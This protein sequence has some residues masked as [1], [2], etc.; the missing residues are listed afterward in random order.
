MNCTRMVATTAVAPLLWGTTYLT[1]T[2]LLP[3]D[4]PLLASAVRALPAGLVLIG[5]TRTLPRGAWWWKSAVLGILNIGGFFALLFVSA[6]RLPGGVSATLGAVHPLIVAVLAVLVLREPHRPRTWMTAGLGLLG[7]AMLVLTPS[8]RLDGV[9][10]AA[11]LLAGASAACGVILTK[12]WGRPVGLVGFTGWQLAWGGLV[13][14]VPAVTLEGLPSGLTGTNLLGF[15]WLAGP[16]AVVAYL[17]WFRGVLALPATQVSVLTFLA[18]LTAVVLGWAVLDQSLT[19]LQGWGAAVIV[20]S[21]LWG[22]RRDA[23]SR[24]ALPP[25]RV[26]IHA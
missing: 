11:G 14:L 3:P 12:R 5:L 10:I 22:Q 15:G 1:T 9:G 26:P 20:A 16:G 2:E 13:L 8:V 23:S 6:Y 17:L 24:A 19:W 21:V 4:R 7:V 25:G 18:P